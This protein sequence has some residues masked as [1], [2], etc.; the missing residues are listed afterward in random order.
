MDINRDMLSYPNNVLSYPKIIS[1]RYLNV[2][3]FQD[4]PRYLRMSFWGKLLDERSR[5]PLNL[6]CPSVCKSTRNAPTALGSSP[7]TSTAYA[8]SCSGCG[9]ALFD[10]HPNVVCY[11]LK[12]VRIRAQERVSMVIRR[13]LKWGSGG[14]GVPLWSVWCPLHGTLLRAKESKGVPKANVCVLHR[15]CMAV[16]NGVESLVTSWLSALVSCCLLL[17]MLAWLPFAAVCYG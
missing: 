10:S 17:F 16:A 15:V 3:T 9:P 12:R 4:I 5:H 7:R 11:E 1:L 14:A 2:L 6:L 8:S 13:S